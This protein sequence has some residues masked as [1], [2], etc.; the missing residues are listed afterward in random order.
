MSTFVE[1]AHKFAI[2]SR[3]KIAMALC[4]EKMESQLS[5]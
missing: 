1:P 2:G 3:L 4:G 5:K